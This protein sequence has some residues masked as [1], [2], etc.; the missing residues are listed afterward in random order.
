ML[1]VST[2]E[3]NIQYT[4]CVSFASWLFSLH[5]TLNFATVLFINVK[6]PKLEHTLCKSVSGIF[7]R[8]APLSSDNQRWVT[9]ADK[10]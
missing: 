6:I 3:I 1:F 8:A 2:L 10:K 5:I 4:I 9:F 7:L